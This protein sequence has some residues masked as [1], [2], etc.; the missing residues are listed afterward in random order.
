MNAVSSDTHPEGSERTYKN[1]HQPRARPM[2][3]LEQLI[4]KAETGDVRSC[5]E[6]GQRFAVGNGTD[7]DESE[8]FGWYY[9]AAKKGYGPAQF[10]IGT[11]YANGIV[12]EANEEEAA[13]WY[14]RASIMGDLDAYRALLDYY[15]T[16]DTPEDGAV[17][18]YFGKRSESEPEAMFILG[19]LH[20]LGVGT[21]FAPQK[22]YECYNAAYEMGDW[23][24]AYAVAMSN[25]YGLGVPRDRAK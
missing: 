23:N 14:F 8:A 7:A 6:L 10:V 18:E 24:G 21:P 1:R 22:A 2:E 25:L 5:F 13:M 19:K 9:M 4:S 11:C 16:H 17:F 3:T 12:V 20:E 15:A